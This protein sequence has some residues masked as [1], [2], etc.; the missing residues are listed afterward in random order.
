MRPFI[1][2]KMQQMNPL[3][4]SELSYIQWHSAD[5]RNLLQYKTVAPVGDR[6]LVKVD[7][8]EEKSLGGILLPSS[9][10]K[11]PT[12]GHVEKA[13]TAKA[14]RVS[15]CTVHLAQPCS[16]C[17]P[18]LLGPSGKPYLHTV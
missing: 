11:K 18:L 3:S 4:L 7:V 14:V 1:A 8:S 5:I 9:S 2:V 13:G 12:Q 16:A 10:Q 17:N 6:V 15:V